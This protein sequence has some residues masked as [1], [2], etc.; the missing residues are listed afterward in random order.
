MKSLTHKQIQDV[1]LKVLDEAQGIVELYP[2]VYGNKDSYNERMMYGCFSD[3]LQK[4]PPNGL[5]MHNWERPVAKTLEWQ[6]RE[7]GDSR[8]PSAI[9]NNG[10]LYIKAQFNLETQEGRDCFSN[11]K[12]GYVNEYSIGYREIESVW[13]TAEKCKDVTKVKLYEWSSVIVGANDATLT[14]SAKSFDAKQKGVEIFERAKAEILG[15]DAESCMTFSAIGELAGRLYWYI[16]YECC[17]GESMSKAD[18]MLM[19]HSACQEF[20]ALSS[21]VMDALLP[22]TEGDEMEMLRLQVN[23]AKP[24]DEKSLVSFRDG[25]VHNKELTA[26][27]DLAKLVSARMDSVGKLRA[28][29]RNKEGRVFSSANYSALDECCTE[30]QG[31]CDTMRELLD[32]SKPEKSENFQLYIQK[33]RAKKLL[34]KK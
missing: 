9:K 5:F 1:H 30:L 12:G 28:I 34:K 21:I 4:R 13:N 29:D 26:L 23:A 2:S 31:I 27:R 32:S 11:I 16:A 18:K 8:L 19:W 24:C 15:E 22:E 17:Y 25:T 6:E 3:E 14:V 7:A 10:G 20:E 33:Q